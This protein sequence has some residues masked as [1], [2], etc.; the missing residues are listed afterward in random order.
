M[1][2]LKVRIRLSCDDHSTKH[3]KDHEILATPMI[4]LLDGTRAGGLARVAG[5]IL[6]LLTFAHTGHSEGI[7]DTYDHVIAEKGK[8]TGK[9]EA[10]SMVVLQY[11]DV[12]IKLRDG[13][14]VSIKAVEVRKAN[15]AP[16]PAPQSAANP[17]GS[18]A[19]GIPALKAE[20]RATLQQVREIVNQPVTQVPI[21]DG[22]AVEHFPFWFH[23]G[24]GMPNFDDDDV[25]TSQS[26]ANYSS[27]RYEYATSPLNSGIAFPLSE[28]AFNGATKIF[29][30]D[31]TIPKK[32]LT[33][34]ELLEINRLYR[35]IGRDLRLLRALGENPSIDAN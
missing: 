25:R 33:E 4:T 29:Y 11:P 18:G 35:I 24:A 31:R 20:L 28:M 10:G 12:T 15:P 7:G 27:P 2:G 6:A 14:V 9:I 8:P 5:S 26:R 3:H 1:L 16:T 22:M 34:E 30:R 17:S 19:G 23:D 32:M 13:V 21:S